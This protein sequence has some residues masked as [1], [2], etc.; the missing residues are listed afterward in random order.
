MQA[1]TGDKRFTPLTLTQAEKIQF[2]IDKISDRNMINF[3]EIKDIDPTK[4]GI[5]AIHRAYNKLGTVLP[6]MSAKIMTG[7]DFIPVLE[8]KLEDKNINDKNYIFY[9]MQTQVETNY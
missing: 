3:A 1:L 7:D 5:I 8:N 9:S 2:R 6:N 4:N